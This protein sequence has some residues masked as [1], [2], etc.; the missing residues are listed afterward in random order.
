MGSKV[1]TTTL[2]TQALEALEKSTKMFEVARR[3]LQQGNIVEA[4]RIRNDARRQRT[5]SVWLMTNA[6]AGTPE[7][8][9]TSIGP[10]PRV[11]SA[12]SAR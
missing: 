2:Q 8:D 4:E 5:L 9:N 3:L 10:P 6:N 7:V 1:Q 12:R 11:S